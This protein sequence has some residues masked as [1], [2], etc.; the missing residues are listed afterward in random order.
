[1]ISKIANKHTIKVVRVRAVVNA[2]SIRQAA[3]LLFLEPISAPHEQ[4][5]SHRL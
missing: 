3:T 5:D 2:Q 4:V 1:M